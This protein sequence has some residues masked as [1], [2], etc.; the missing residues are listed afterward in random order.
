MDFY[1]IKVIADEYDKMDTYLTDDDIISINPK[2]LTIFDHIDAAIVAKHNL[3]NR[4]REIWPDYP[5]EYIQ[6]CRL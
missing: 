2:C 5:A 4:L 6:I 1:Y 3:I